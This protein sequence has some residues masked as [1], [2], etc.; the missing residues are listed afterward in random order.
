MT[1]N[2][3]NPTNEPNKTSSQDAWQEVG[4]QFQQLGDSLAA[5]VRTAW[6]DEENRRRIAEMKTGLESMVKEV[7]D[8]IQDT[9][10]TPE[11]QRVKEGFHRTAENLVSAGEQTVQEVRPHLLNALQ[12]LNNELD[13]LVNRM[14]QRQQQATKGPESNSQDPA[15]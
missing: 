10:S 11:G 12:Q 6:N 8:A 3:N 13:K 15:A 9:A 1:E 14:E 4:R 7:G 5:A 2:S